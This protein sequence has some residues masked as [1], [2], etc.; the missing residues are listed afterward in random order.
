MD[1]QRKSPSAGRS[2]DNSR[3][4]E[5]LEA[6]CRELLEKSTMGKVKCATPSLWQ[7]TNEAMPLRALTGCREWA[8]GDHPHPFTIANTVRRA[9]DGGMIYPM[10]LIG[11]GVR[12]HMSFSIEQ[13][14]AWL[15]GE[16][17]A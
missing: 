17:G 11:D 13:A 1:N 12:S 7:W 2:F 10:F 8:A 6:I 16:A 9:S 14:E 5:C 15:R 3:G 4:G